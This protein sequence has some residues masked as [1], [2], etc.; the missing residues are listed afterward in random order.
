MVKRIES[1]DLCEVNKKQL[2]DFYGDCVA[3]GLSK[4]RIA[5]YLDTLWR[6]TLW[7]DKPL[8]DVNREDITK[9]LMRVETSDYTAWTKHDYRAI[10]K[11]F[12]RWLRKTED[13]PDEVRWIRTRAGVSRKLP[14]ELLTPDEVKRMVECAGTLRDKA[15][16]LVLY[17]SGCR[18]GEMLTLQVKHVQFD[19]FGA[20]VLVDGKTGQ[21]RVR[22]IL[23]A[24]KLMQWVENHPL[25]NDPEAPLWL[26]HGT[27]NRNG[28]LG[29]TTACQTLREMA[30]RAGIR[31]RIYPHLFRHSRST[32]MANVLTEAQME[33]YFGWIPGSRMPSIYVH[34]SGRDV[35]G[36][37]L[38]ANGIAVEGT[39]VSEQL[40]AATCP[41]C[42][43][44]SSPDAKFC[45]ICGMCLDEKTAVEVDDAR[46][47]ADRLMDELVKRPEILE[48]MLRAVEAIK[49]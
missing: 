1:S 23:S 3:R 41:R 9:L 15:L 11:V 43:K 22:L 36:A 30:V 2:L 5:K 45:S 39:P 10:L 47:K 20:V 33:G 12:F 6:I 44:A 13:Y 38:R 7:L 17:E 28:P 46:Q 14:E 25:R 18:I 35:D 34:L 16:V 4:A 8:P 42:G 31:K 48:Q 26:T 27:R 32:H 29:Y 37:I 24:P 40:R 21:R 49:D 19:K